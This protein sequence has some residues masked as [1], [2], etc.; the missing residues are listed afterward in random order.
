M[1][2]EKYKKINIIILFLCTSFFSKLTY[3][4]I[5]NIKIALTCID[6]KIFFLSSLYQNDI[7]IKKKKYNDLNE[8]I[9]DILQINM[10]NQHNFSITEKELKEEIKRYKKLIIFFKNDI[11]YVNKN[12]KKNIIF[13]KFY[14][15]KIFK[16][17]KK[18]IN[19][20]LELF[21][22]NNKIKSQYHIGNVFLPLTNN[23]CYLNIM[24]KKLL[25]YVIIKNL[26][27]VFSK[28]NIIFLKNHLK[29]SHKHKMNKYDVTNI[30][31]IPSIILEYINFLH[32][33]PTP[34]PLYTKKGVYLTKIF[35]RIVDN[36]ANN[37]NLYLY[38]YFYKKQFLKLKNNL[39][40]KM[41]PI[42]IFLINNIFMR[43]CWL[44]EKK[45]LKKNYAIDNKIYF[46]YY[47]QVKNHFFIKDFKILDS[48]SED[49]FYNKKLEHSIKIWK[50]FLYKKHL[51]GN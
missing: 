43:S 33:I 47:K 39:I 42:K 51:L 1:S 2:T 34:Y 10:V 41:L 25:I 30:N 20:T 32:Y 22:I 37:L 24:R 35:S 14:R 11:K 21:I 18:K 46:Q 19:K 26:K 48:L 50:V 23:K 9:R 4:N 28:N 49:I 36:R 38:L 45:L 6:D 17:N 3:G 44:V 15:K 16:K 12:I 8:K 27:L 5:H 13:K 29:Y 31:N 7:K 40:K